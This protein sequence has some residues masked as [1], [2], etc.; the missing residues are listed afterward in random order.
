MALMLEYSTEV[1]YAGW[2]LNEDAVDGLL[3]ALAG[4]GPAITADAERPRVRLTILAEDPLSAA[5]HAVD[6][7]GGLAP[8]EARPVGIEVQTMEDLERRLQEPDL[9]DLVGVAEIARL[10]GVTKQRVSELA[11][12]AGFPRPVASLASGPVWLRPHVSRFVE[13]WSRRPGRPRKAAAT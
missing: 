1:A 3:D 2:V 9:P 8:A 10:I 4:H 6:L 7:L 11:G 13:S 12:R 5:A